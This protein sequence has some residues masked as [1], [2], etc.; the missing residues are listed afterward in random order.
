MV[1]LSEVV[2]RLGGDR[3]F[4]AECADLFSEE[5]PALL[6]SLRE[7]LRLASADQVNRIAHALKGAASN[8]CVSGPTTVAGEIERLAGDGR[9]EDADRLLPALERE[10]DQLLDTLR[11]LRPGRAW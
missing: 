10:L 9:L 2:A 1:N 6:G 7:G 3:E 4:A 5:L 11:A 8:F